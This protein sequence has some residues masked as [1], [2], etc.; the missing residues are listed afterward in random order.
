MCTNFTEWLDDVT[1]KQEQL[2]AH[3]TPAFL[4]QQVTSKLEP[5]EKEVRRLIKK[6]KPKPPKKAANATNATSANATNGTS[7]NT[8]S[9]GKEEEL[10]PH[11]EL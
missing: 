9:G 8:T 4:S 2:A 3:E 1:A 6:P 11:D 7:A 5:I 10:P